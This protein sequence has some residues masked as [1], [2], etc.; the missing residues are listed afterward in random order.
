M[1]TIVLVGDGMGDR[2]CPELDNKTP[3]Q[4]ANIPNMRRIAAA[5]K[6]YMADTVPEGLPPGSDVANLGLLGYDARDFYTGRAPIEAA[7]AGLPLEADDVAIR[8]NLVNIGKNEGTEETMVDYSSGHISSEEAAPLIESLQAAL[9]RDGLTFH[10]GVQYRHLLIWKQGPDQPVTQPPHDILG[11]KIAPYLPQ[12]NRAEE[13]QALM[14]ASKEIFK[15]HPVNRARRERGD[16]PVTQIWLWGQGPALK[17]PT[18]Q[19][20]YGM[21]G[22]IITAV[23]LVRGLGVLAGLDTPKVEGATGW[24]DTNYAG[25]VEAA[26]EALKTR[27][28]AYVHVE[29]PDEC[30]HVG[31]AKLKTRAIEDFDA[32]VVGPIWDAL[33]AIGAPYRLL[34]TMDHRTP[35]EIRGHSAEPVPLATLQGPVGKVTAQTAFD[36]FVN[37]G[38]S[39]IRTFEWIPRWLRGEI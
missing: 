27:D 10:A 13:L 5:G 17:L 21:S 39:E 6:L 4:A 19:T 11:Q 30:G 8:C 9:G 33:E 38:K 16:V 15:D 26:L 36:E 24:I 18:Y 23:D 28:F 25:K 2:P 34:V 12:G 37:D 32:K 3:L 31:D 29:A 22:T 1:K 7:G 14:E 35:V 20:L